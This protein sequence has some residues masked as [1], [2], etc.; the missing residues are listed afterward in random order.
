MITVLK[1]DFRE[2]L[3]KV[4]DASIDCLM[5]DPPYGQTALH[6]DKPVLGWQTAVHRVL[7]PTGSMWVFGTLRHFMAFG[8]H[9]TG[10][11]MSHDIVWE[12]HN[13]SGFLDDR[14]RCVHEI[15][16]HFY[17]D[18]AKWADVYKVPQF[19][20]DATARTVRRKSK[21]AHWTGA[22]GPSYYTSQDGGPRLMRSVQYVRSE[23]GR[24]EHPTQKPLGIVEPL[25]LY[26][27]PKGGTVLDPFAGSGTVGALA[28]RHGMHCI[29]IEA[30]PEYWPV[31]ERR[32]ED[33]FA[34]EPL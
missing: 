28:A 3:G 17:R 31:I 19:T 15:A 4:P 12:K 29:L 26:A 23:H 25:L 10:W 24:A 6:W 1:G 13:G 11:Q 18:D 33:L 32:K 16:A 14:F 20:N 9:F 34:I 5:V 27:C 7:K 2:M 30:D 22:R 21:P 8:G